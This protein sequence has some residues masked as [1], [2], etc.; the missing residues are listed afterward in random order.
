MC[1]MLA[2]FMVLAVF[3]IKSIRRSIKKRKQPN[4]K[5]HLPTI[6][7]TLTLVLC[8]AIPGSET[9][10]SDAVIVAGY[11]GTQNQNIIKFRKNNTFEMNSTAVFGYNEWYT[12]TYNRKGDTLLL[13]YETE[14]PRTIGRK[15]VEK[16]SLLITIDKPKDTTDCCIP[17]HIYKKIK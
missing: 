8:Y 13:T 2:I 11:E 16:D 5:T 14:K 7:Y 17:L 1:F 12:G 4:L 15:L 3:F 10:E 6:I 9:F